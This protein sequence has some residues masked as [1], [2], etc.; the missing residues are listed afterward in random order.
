M[1]ESRPG[2]RVAIVAGVRT[3]FL[4]SG[5]AFRPSELG[6]PT[7]ADTPDDLGCER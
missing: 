7:C 5:T 1:Q 3:P 2:R 4:K 6:G